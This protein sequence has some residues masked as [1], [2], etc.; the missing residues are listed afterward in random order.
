MA[1]RGYPGEPLKGTRILGI[2]EAERVPGVA[3]LQ[4][5]TRQVADAIVADG[6]RVLAVTATGSTVG[7]AQERA[8]TAIQR[9]E[10]PEGFC[11]KDI[12]WRAVAR[13]KGLGA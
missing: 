7:E 6:G 8:Y 10:W 2:E 13:E 5:G 1:A 9:I 3:V 12:G 4:A 11:R